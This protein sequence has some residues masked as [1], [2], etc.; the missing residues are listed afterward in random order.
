MVKAKSKNDPGREQT[1]ERILE[2]ARQRL[3]EEG[4]ARLSTR[5]IAA[6]AGVNH[7]LIHYYFGTKDQ[8]VIAVLDEANRR[9]LARQTAMYDTPGGF[10]EK[11]A[12]AR[13]FY[14]EDLASGFVRLQM[15]LW[16]ASLSNPELRAVFLPRLLAW[17]RVVRDAVRDA[18][19]HYELDLPVS[20]DMV[21][22]WICTY[23]GG[24]EFEMLIGMSE[25]DGHHQTALATVQRLLEYLD[26]R[27]TDAR[28]AAGA[29]A[30]GAD[31]VR[32]LHAAS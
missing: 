23:W 2:A 16:A 13:A 7:A 15:E 12:R 22:D 11:W 14:E 6:E 18:V 30:D 25:E 17:R 29:G 32:E 3:V 9:L 10:A 28:A 8:L 1:R 20:P 5:Q 27:A 19:A 24:M 4:Y 26:R 31:I 21:A